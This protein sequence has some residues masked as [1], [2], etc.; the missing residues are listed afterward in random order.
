LDKTFLQR[1]SNSGNNDNS[2]NPLTAGTNLQVRQQA[3]CNGIE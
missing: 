1:K 3:A 2:F